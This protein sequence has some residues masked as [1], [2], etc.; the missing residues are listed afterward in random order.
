MRISAI[1][2]EE[3]KAVKV[4]CDVGDTVFSLWINPQHPTIGLK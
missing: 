3:E 2:P 4:G 1:R